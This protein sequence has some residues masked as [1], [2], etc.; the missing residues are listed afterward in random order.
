MSA[1]MS[2][3]GP[4]AL[5]LRAL[6]VGDLLTAVPAIRAVRV[7]LPRHRLVLAAPAALGDLIALIGGVD[8][9][10]GADGLCPL[11]WPG[12]GP[13]VAINLHGRGPQSHEILRAIGPS[14][15]LG[16]AH[17]AHPDVDG[18]DWLPGEHE[19]ARWCRLA[20]WYG[21]PAR[22]DD[23]R[24]L[25]PGASPA[26]GAVLVHP[27]AKHGSRRWPAPRFAEVVRA[28]LARGERVV[29]TGGRAEAALAHAVG[30]QAGIPRAEVLAGKTTL[31]ELA[32][33]V[34]AARLVICNDTGIAHLASA[35]G[36]PSVVLFGPTPP[37]QWGPPPRP[38]HAALWAGDPGDPFAPT[39][40]EGLLRI[41]V[42]DVLDAARA[43][44]GAR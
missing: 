17:P 42:P 43:V 40:A 22:P 20:R 37:A 13:T 28:L 31:G 11:P 36:T 12:Q 9:H 38:Q 14:R 30:A 26:P 7:G 33:L 8:A 5:V 23:L 15:L 41:M 10:L 18:P 3:T 32:A 29:V 4:V 2:T 39:P 16:F 27:G 34:A 44:L 19:V 21:F 35:Y 1:P 24:L 25:P 6:G